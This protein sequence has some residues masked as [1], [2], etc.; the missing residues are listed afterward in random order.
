MDAVRKRPSQAR[1]RFRWTW[2][3]LGGAFLTVIGLTAAS[4]APVLGTSGAGRTRVQQQAGGVLVV[5][6]WIALGVSIHAIGRGN[7]E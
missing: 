3:A 7:P 6:G 5:L 2:L 1:T 4:I